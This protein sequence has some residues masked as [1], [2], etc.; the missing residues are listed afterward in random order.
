MERYKNK[1]RVGTIRLKDWDY[2]SN[3]CYFVTICTKNQEPFFGDWVDG[4]L[5]LKDVGKI[6]ECYWRE[7]PVHFPCV[8]LDAFVVMPNHVHGI[9][10]IE[11][12]VGGNVETLHC[13]GRDVAGH[14]RD[15]AIVNRRDVAW[16]SRFYEK[17][18]RGERDFHHIRQY[19]MNNPGN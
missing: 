5:V 4:R 19:I 10:N 15:V 13:V 7:I 8:K 6:A 1:Y 3:G 18:I 17:I 11:K 12:P 14:C 2:S 16:Q 9:I